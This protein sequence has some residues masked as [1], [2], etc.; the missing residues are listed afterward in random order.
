[1]T[2]TLTK[3]RFKL[4]CE[5]PTKLYYTRK[6]RE[7]ADQSLDDSFLQALAEGGFQVGELAKCYYPGGHDITTLD[8]EEALAQTSALLQQEGVVIFE[9]AVRIENLFIRIDILKKMGNHLKLVEVKAKSWS[10]VKPLVSD[11]GKIDGKWGTKSRLALLEF[12]RDAGLL[13]NGQPDKADYDA[14]VAWEVE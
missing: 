7:Y 4:A 10:G 2:R 12:E 3:S 8:A 1:M 5:C 9:A 14:L 6:K 13:E 11:K